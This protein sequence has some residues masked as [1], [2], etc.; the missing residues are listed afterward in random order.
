MYLYENRILALDKALVGMRQKIN[1][2]FFS[3][4]MLYIANICH[5]VRVTNY[6][7]PIWFF[8]KGDN[9]KHIFTSIFLNF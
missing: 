6:I 9:L 8:Y 2:T 5:Q 7:G 4:F 1:F 3:L